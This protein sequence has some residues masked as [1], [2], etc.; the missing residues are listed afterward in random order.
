MLR[1]LSED[2]GACYARADEC[3]READEAFSE[4]TR[5]DLLRLHQSRVKLACS[6][7]FAERLLDFSKDNN[8]RR[9]EFYG[10][11]EPIR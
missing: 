5:Q 8:R 1:K 2:A 10:D 9:A 3:A 7:E 6:Y 11:G 4:P